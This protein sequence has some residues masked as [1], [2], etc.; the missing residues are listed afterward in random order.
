MTVLEHAL[1]CEG[2]DDRAA[3][4]ALLRHWGLRQEPSG[5]P[6]K[7]ATVWTS[8]S[9]RVL[10]AVAD[11][12]SD[13]ARRLTM[14]QTAAFRP[15]VVGVS[16]DPDSDP[17]ATE[18]HFLRAQFDSVPRAGAL[19]VDGAGLVWR[20]RGQSIPVHFAA[21]RVSDGFL[22]DALPDDWHSLERVL[23]SGLWGALRS[24]EA[25]WLEDAIAS[26]G[27]VVPKDRWKQ[28]LHLA[29]ALLDPSVGG[30][31]FVDRLFQAERT[32]H[33]CLQALLRS[34]AVQTLAE[35]ARVTI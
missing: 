9:V 18:R 13:L 34:T 8:P 29:N 33:A 24:S 3:I 21:W 4:H 6:M 5:V 1:V 10:V 32:K 25:K 30:P 28:A 26:L 17:R 22:K 12:K 35:V 20:T 14:T 16:F 11:G 7:K 31:A 23:L 27:T 19:E 2:P 15:T